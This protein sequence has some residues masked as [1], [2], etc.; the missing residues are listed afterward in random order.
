MLSCPKRRAGCAHT[1]C[2]LLSH[3]ALQHPSACEPEREGEKVSLPFCT[4]GRSLHWVRSYKVL[5]QADAVCALSWC[6]RSHTDNLCRDFNPLCYSRGPPV[7]NK[8]NK[9]FNVG[10][11]C[12]SWG[13]LG[14]GSQLQAQLSG[15]I[16]PQ[17]QAVRLFAHG[18][19]HGLGW[20]G[21]VTAGADRL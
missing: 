21:G 10:C 2:L 5:S 7:V 4:F 1:R 3:L 11:V 18:S 12:K 16:F 8:L 13:V 19:W 9:K 15:L 17:N 20:P 14:R 6:G